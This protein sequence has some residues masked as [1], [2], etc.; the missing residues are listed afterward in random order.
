[1]TREV[2]TQIQGGVYYSERKSESDKYAVKRYYD[3]L[4]ENTEK[5]KILDAINKVNLAR[6]VP[7]E[8]LIRTIGTA[9]KKVSTIDAPGNIIPYFYLFDI[10]I[11]NSF[12]YIYL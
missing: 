2:V 4:Q 6:C 11:I 3:Q 12:I 10:I 9:S 5:P 8:L 1:M 7:A